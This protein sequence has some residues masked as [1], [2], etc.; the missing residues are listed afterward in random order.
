[1]D[2]GIVLYNRWAR[3]AGYAQTRLV[4]RDP[5]IIDQTDA[6]ILVQG[7]EIEVLKCPPQRR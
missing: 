2:K 6:L 5:L 3:F 7:Q 4:S 1:V